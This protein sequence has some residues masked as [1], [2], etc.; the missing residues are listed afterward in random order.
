MFV[1]CF[2]DF[3]AFHK[4]DLIWTSQKSYEVAGQ[5]RWASV[6]R[7]IKWFAGWMSWTVGSGALRLRALS[8][9]PTRLPLLLLSH[10]LTGEARVLL[11]SYLHPASSIALDKSLHF[12]KPL[13]FLICEIR[14]WLSPPPRFWEW[15]REKCLVRAHPVPA[16]SVIASRDMGA[17]IRSC[18]YAWLQA[19]DRAA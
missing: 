10:M 5:E 17:V 15:W 11:T 12:F 4:W 2:T 1:K 8:S 18:G 16:W 7:E 14:K 3:K 6:Y 9:C 19:T 13:S